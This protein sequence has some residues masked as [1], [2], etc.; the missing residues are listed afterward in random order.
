MEELLEQFENALILKQFDKARQL[1]NKAN[2]KGYN[3]SKMRNM[4]FVVVD[5]TNNV[6]F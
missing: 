4:Y 3:V 5:D 1:I 6:I 2:E